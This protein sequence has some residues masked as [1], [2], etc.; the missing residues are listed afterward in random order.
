MLS[1][2]DTDLLCRVGP[3]TPMG[4]LMRRYWLPVGYSWEYECDGQP[5][6]VRVLGEDLV[7]WRASDGTPAFTEPQC[8]HRGAGLFYGRNEE[9]GIRCAYHGWKFDASGQCV[10]MPNEPAESAFRHKVRIRAYRGADYGGVTWIYMGPRQ[11]DPPGVPQFEWGQTPPENVSHAQKIVYECN[12]MQALEGELDSTHVYFLHRRLNADD[13]PRYGLFHNDRRARFHIAEKPYGFTYGAERSELDGNVYWRTTQFLF[14]VYGMFP[15]Q[16]GVVPLSVYLPIDDHHTLHMGIWWNPAGAMPGAADGYGAPHEAL[17][18]EP[19]MLA[20]GVGPMKPE[21]R[22]RFFSK[23]WPQ[24][25]PD[26][27]F[28]MDVR[29]KRTRNATGIPTVRLQDSA[30]I[31]SMGRIM[32][33]TREHLGTTDVSIIRA[34]RMLLRAAARLR[35]DGTPPPGSE[36]PQDYYVRS[37]AAIL[38]PGADWEAE[39]DDWHNCRTSEP[40]RKVAESNRAFKERVLPGEP[41]YRT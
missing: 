26:S 17:A 38:P 6:R 30:V 5:Q 3:G 21:Q 10:D 8:P 39:L 29:A 33:R 14:P 28:L 13:S 9:S 2:E 4:E 12:W 11:G 34:R 40:P 37:C 35:E 19:G 41:A 25:A 16:D 31:H 1:A 18:E 23:W 24:A 22:G 27:D 15:A 36:R 7:V 32:D 20:P